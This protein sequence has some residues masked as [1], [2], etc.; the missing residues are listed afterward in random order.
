VTDTTTQARWQEDASRDLVRNAGARLA[1]FTR[2]EGASVWDDSGRRYLDFLGGIAVTSLGHAHP[3]FVDAIARQAATL[4][5][6]SNYFATPPQLELA[7]LLKEIAGAGETGRV[8]FGNSGAEA[9]EAA[10]K[11][12]RLHGA[13]ARNG[14]TPRPR[15]LALE[16]AFHGRTM[17][18]LALTGKPYMQEPFLP[19]VP[20]VEFLESTVEA[21]EAA[22]DD[23]VAALFVEPIKGEAGVV[24]LPEGYLRAARE[25]TRRHGALL[26]VDE[27]QTGA[28]RTGEWFAFQHEDITPDAITVA[29]GIG[30]GFPIGAL[31]TFGE[32]SDLFYPG[33]HGSTFGGNALG[34]A[35]AVAVL[36]EIER[37]GLLANAAERGAQVRAA[38]KGLNSPL[39]HETRGRGLLIGVGLRHP[40]AGAV[41]AAAQQHG[42]IV[43]AANEDTVRLAPALTIGDVEV[44]EFTDLFARALHTVEDSLLLDDPTA[45]SKEPA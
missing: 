28:G 18:T 25:I 41:V 20:G 22:M 23:R 37:A 7:A 2:G 39:V 17:G 35:V 10:F 4:A 1:M 40:V 5:H 36:R 16:N 15:I 45:D 43:N 34:T 24:E 38:I 27:I 29:K 13:A 30:G 14:G 8:Y 32:A 9:N 42:L 44:D 21:L 12:A 11:L 19:M 31:I 3:V 6:V 26:I 33:T